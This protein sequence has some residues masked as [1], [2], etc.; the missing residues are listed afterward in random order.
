MSFWAVLILITTDK[1]DLQCEKSL[2]RIPH[3]WKSIFKTASFTWVKKK[4]SKS[5]PTPFSCL[6]K[7]SKEPQGGLETNNAKISWRNQQEPL[8]LKE[9]SGRIRVFKYMSLQ[10]LFPPTFGPSSCPYWLLRLDWERAGCWYFPWGHLGNNS[11]GSD[12]SISQG[13]GRWLCALSAG[14]VPYRCFTRLGTV[15]RRLKLEGS[16]IPDPP[17]LPCSGS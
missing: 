6:G 10:P 15:D 2:V 12:P 5:Q 7:H 8:H 1:Q 3:D 9:D 16:L 14:W 4:I 11:G 13:L 17:S